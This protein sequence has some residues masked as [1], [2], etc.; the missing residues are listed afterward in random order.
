M[1]PLPRPKLRF[2]AMALA[3]FTAA[4]VAG[5]AQ[6][7]PGAPSTLAVLPL[8]GVFQVPKPGTAYPGQGQGQLNPRAPQGLAG[9]R[10]VGLEAQI[11]Q[12]VT[13]AFFKTG[14]FQLIEREQL[15][16]VLKEGKFEQSGLVDDATAARL[17]KQIGATY[18]LVGSY[19][20]SIGHTV[21][22]KTGFFGGKSREDSYP[23][24]LEVRLRLVNTEDGSIREAILLH[25]TSLD[26]KAYHSYELLLDDLSSSL[27]KDA[28]ARFP[29]MGYVI[30]VI[31]DK[32]VLVDLGQN[33]RIEKGAGFQLVEQGED[34]VH[35][36]TGKRIKGE[37]RVLT[38]LKVTDV[39]EESS[40][41]K[42]TGA[43]TTLK[44]GQTVVQAP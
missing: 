9:A 7:A 22:V 2:Q 43:R 36:V 29:L 26:P 33:Q 34:V 31:S 30:K 37:R 3:L 35:P 11:N 6:P 24:H 27:D 10:I 13:M 8:S 44:V 1:S 42:V 5:W 41:L 38:D 16:T 23:G 32:E 14:R 20:G 15:N 19:T 21:E 4:G 25:A 28:A 12:R 18:V 17:G 39:G 40:T